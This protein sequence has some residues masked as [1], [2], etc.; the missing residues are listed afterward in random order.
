MLASLT[1]ILGEIDAWWIKNVRWDRKSTW[2]SSNFAMLSTSRCRHE[3]YLKFC[4]DV[5]EYFLLLVDLC[6]HLQH[7][8]VI[9]WFRM[10]IIK[11]G[12][13]NKWTACGP[14]WVSTRSALPSNI[15][16]YECCKWV[17]LV[18]FVIFLH[19]YSYNIYYIFKK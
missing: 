11:S 1:K 2:K 10:S 8:S 4:F 14:T 12:I 16:Q 6:C 13:S 3:P 7:C 19:L 18:K 17:V 15:E 9:L 5:L